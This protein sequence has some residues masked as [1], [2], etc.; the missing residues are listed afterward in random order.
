METKERIFLNRWFL[1]LLAFSVMALL[2]SLIIQGVLGL[3]PC[4]MCILQRIFLILLGL[5]AGFGLL[6]FCKWEFFKAAQVFLCLGF[7]LGAVHFLMQM[8]AF[9]D[10]CISYRGVFSAEEFSR[11]LRASK[12]SDVSWSVLGVPVSLMN[13]VAQGSLLGTSIFLR[14]RKNLKRGRG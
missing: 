11:M 4:L 3:K 6:S 9:P 13:A 5:N 1:G 10:F 12:C 8:G 2:F 14:F 7:V